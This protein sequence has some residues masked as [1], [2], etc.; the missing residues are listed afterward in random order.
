MCFVNYLL[1]R[2]FRIIHVL[3]SYSEQLAI[4]RLR[5]NCRVDFAVHFG[6][7]LGNEIDAIVG[8]M[9][10]INP[11]PPQPRNGFIDSSLEPTSCHEIRL[12]VVYISLSCYSLMYFWLPR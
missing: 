7:V 3:D 4:P 11:F 9:P 6:T 2:C 10:L 12:I 8:N 1:Q 5:K